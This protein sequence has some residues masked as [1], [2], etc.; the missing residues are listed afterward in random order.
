MRS[1]RRLLQALAAAL[2]WAPRTA[3]AVAAPRRFGVLIGSAP[4]TA[5]GK[6]VVSA[7]HDAMAKLGYVEGRT[8]LIEWQFANEHYDRMPALARELVRRQVEVMVVFTTRAALEA[9]R[10]TGT[11][12]IV[13]AGISD[14]VGSGVVSNLARPEANITGVSGA[15]DVVVLK[16]LDLLRTALPG[17]VRVGVMI[18]P[19]NAGFAKILQALQRTATNIGITTTVV[20]AGN[21]PQTE[22]AF[23]QL[24]RRRVQALIVFDDV[25]FMTLRAIIAQQAIRAGLPTIANAREFADEGMLFSYGEHLRVQIARAAS[26]VDKVLRGAS[27]GELPVEQPLAYPLT[28]NQK[29]ARALGLDLDTSLLLRADEVIE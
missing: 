3:L 5:L 23:S 20:Y 18:N 6:R 13:F 26:Y 25:V 1:R 24:K 2:W 19:D 8:V 12:P 4:D 9:K 7:F 22:Q 14:P 21:Q 15:A 16:H 17:L 28:I 27:P 29:T 10:A 11:I